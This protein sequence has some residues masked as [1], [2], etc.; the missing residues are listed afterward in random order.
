MKF[1][2]K[3]LVSVAALAILLMGCTLPQLNQS[4]QPGGNQ[5]PPG[6][7]IQQDQLCGYGSGS[8]ASLIPNQSQFYGKCCQ[9]LACVNG[10]CKPP[11]EGCAGSDQFCGYGPTNLARYDSPTYYGEC[12]QGECVNG[13]C[14]QPCKTSGTC[15]ASSECCSGRECREG[16]CIQPCRTTGSCSINSDCCADYYCQNGVCAKQ[17]KTSGS[18]SANADCCSGYFCG[19]NLQCIPEPRCV[20]HRGSCNNTWQ[21]CSGLTCTNGICSNESCKWGTACNDTSECC[22]G[23]YCGQNAICGI[24]RCNELGGVCNTTDECCFGRRCTNNTCVNW[25]CSSLN[26]SC[27]FFSCCSGLTCMNGRCSTPCKS[28]GTC[29]RDSEC[30]SNYYCSPMGYCVARANCAYEFASCNNNTLCCS[31]LQC[32]SGKCSQPCKITGP[33]ESNAECCAGYFCNQ[34]LQCALQPQAPP[35]TL[36]CGQICAGYEGYQNMSVVNQVFHEQTNEANCNAYAKNQC[37]YPNS[38]VTS[39]CCCWKCSNKEYCNATCKNLGY[40]Y[41][42]GMVSNPN[43]CPQGT[44]GYTIES[45]GFCC[46]FRQELPPP[47]PQCTIGTSNCSMACLMVYGTQTSVC[48]ASSCPSGYTQLIGE[49]SCSQNPPCDRCCCQMTGEPYTQQTCQ[50]YSQ[51]RNFTHYQLT[52]DG[53]YWQFQDCYTFAQVHCHDYHNGGTAPNGDAKKNCCVW[54]CSD[55][56]T[57]PQPPT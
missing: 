34:S 52:V 12:C 2:G 27:A 16:K 24:Q 5:T 45:N 36:T 29:M 39:G 22:T 8:P 56:Y 13:Y 25:T 7:C 43:Q 35:T 33:C 17:C 57:P 10:S 40:D 15:S 23:L 6:P 32:I 47:T 53:S 4:G 30:C 51:S 21:C 55:E 38:T 48:G 46:C 50:A 14:K 9:G 18:C 42:S 28:S 20:E 41:S 19:P 49:V 1:F 44:D 26:E 31:G 11:N 3:F 37:A 54:I